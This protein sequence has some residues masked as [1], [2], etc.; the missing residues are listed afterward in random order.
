MLLVVVGIFGKFRVGKSDVVNIGGLFENGDVT[1]IYAFN[2]AIDAYQELFDEYNLTLNGIYTTPGN[3]SIEGLAT[4]DGIARLLD[5][6][7]IGIIG[8]ETDYDVL[9]ASATLDAA[10]VPYIAVKIILEDFSFPDEYPYFFR[11]IPDA[12]GYAVAFSKMS[13]VSIRLM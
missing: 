13:E 7:V 3:S 12:N 4:L 2:A 11:M 9:V 10:T 8:F 5:E 6:Q 1:S